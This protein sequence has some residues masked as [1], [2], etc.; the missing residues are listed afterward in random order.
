MKLSNGHQEDLGNKVE[1]YC[2]NPNHQKGKHKAI[3][4]SLAIK[5]TSC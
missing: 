4:S 3:L 2:L 1:D 5:S